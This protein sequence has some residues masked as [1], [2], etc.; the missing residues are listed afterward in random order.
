MED[1]SPAQRAKIRRQSAPQE[2]GEAAVGELNVVPFLD[3]ITNVMMFVLATV[4]VT[5]TATADV[6]PPRPVPNRGGAPPPSL[7]L[8]VLV[9]DDGFSIK[10]R[11]GNVAPGCENAGT[12]LAVGKRD[13]AYDFAALQRCAEK[14]KAASPD[15]ADEKSVTISANPAVRYETLIATMDAVR[16]DDQGA[17]LFPDVSFGVVR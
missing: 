10:A 12:G 11:G 16:L 3:I 15:F 14:L 4:A 2:G 1:L 6:N 7:G 8:S 17:D 5:F 9:V 13:G